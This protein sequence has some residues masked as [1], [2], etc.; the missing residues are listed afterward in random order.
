MS[1]DPPPS[2][3]HA[4]RAYAVL[5]REAESGGAS[6]A[7]AARRAGALARFFSAEQ[8]TAA[9]RR[10]VE[11]DP[12]HFAGHLGLSRMLAATGDVKAARSA[13]LKAFTLAHDPKDR[14][15]AAHDLGEMS[16]RTGKLDDARDAFTAFRNLVEEA[17]LAAPEDPT[18]ARNRAL[19]L[20]RL[21]DLAAA[22]GDLAEARNGYEISLTQSIALAE[23]FPD[24]PQLVADVAA[25]HE[26][27]GDAALASGDPARARVHFDEKRR[28]MEGLCG[29][30]RLNAEWSVELAKAWARLGEVGAVDGDA[31][32]ARAAHESALKIRTALAALDPSNADYSRDLAATW[33]TLAEAAGARG[34]G[35]TAIAAFRQAIGILE[36]LAEPARA[37]D[38]A[39]LWLRLG[40]AAVAAERDKVADEAL[41]RALA[42]SEILA[43][44]ETL[45]ARIAG[46]ALNRLGTL[47]LKQSD[48]AEAERYAVRAR[49]LYAAHAANEKPPD[50][51]ARG[52]AESEMRLGDIALARGAAADALV[53]FQVCVK[54]RRGLVRAAPTGVA[55][56]SALAGA[57]ERCGL[58]AAGA[59][60]ETAAR[61]AWTEMLDILSALADEAPENGAGRRAVALA[62][63]LLA[64]LGGADEANH[65]AQS[66]KIFA[67][68][69]AEGAMEERDVG[70]WRGVNE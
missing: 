51:W 24:E 33:R 58:A 47:A 22:E 32:A 37:R 57:L 9:F 20:G 11:I 12:T 31:E 13:A 63:A 46:P 49:K 26:R 69:D 10:A 8:A 34:E 1:H 21:S 30:D 18:L 60:D 48:I 53:R 5:M 70:L 25:G 14:A 43:R 19:A 6:S 64:T 39:A 50:F 15:I 28:I 40:E 45:W 66:D 61:T 35:D 55:A 17:L 54:V 16:L 41:S 67:L 7:E 2:L 42:A 44:T 52:R 36:R 68:L 29:K 3:D 56:R 23:R 59:G 38:L 65:R 4:R 27:L 62:H